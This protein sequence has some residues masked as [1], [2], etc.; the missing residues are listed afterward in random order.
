M[1]CSLSA[2]EFVGRL[3][4]SFGLVFAR[5]GAIPHFAKSPSNPS[6]QPIAQS[7]FILTCILSFSVE[8]RLGEYRG[9]ALKTSGSGSTLSFQRWIECQKMPFAASTWHFQAASLTRIASPI[10]VMSIDRP[11]ILITNQQ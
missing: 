9:V 4:A 8:L 6:D 7:S 10:A 1:R 3:L 5:T 2:D 11:D